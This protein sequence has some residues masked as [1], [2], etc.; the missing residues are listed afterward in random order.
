MA[1][2]PK[3]GHYRGINAANIIEG[4]LYLLVPKDDSSNRMLKFNLENGER[5][6]INADNVQSF[7]PYGDS[8]A[9]ALVYVP[10]AETQT[11]K[12]AA[13]D[14]SSGELQTIR[15]FSGALPT[16]LAYAQK[17]D[18]VYFADNGTLFA[19]AGSNEPKPVAYIKSSSSDPTLGALVSPEFYACADYYS[20]RVH[21][22]YRSPVYDRHR[23]QSRQRI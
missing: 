2:M 4:Q 14:L 23:N 15:E 16:G 6:E 12:L 22:K 8:G 21:S 17:T 7:T 1:S 18:T 19:I 3:M 11:V 5:G 10:T 13:M 20:G 9:L